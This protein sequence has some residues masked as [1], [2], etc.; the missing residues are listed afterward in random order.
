[1]L[2]LCCTACL[3]L[4]VSLRACRLVHC[5]GCTLFV[6]SP[7]IHHLRRRRRRQHF[8]L[9]VVVLVVVVIVIAVCQPRALSLSSLR[10]PPS[11]W[12]L[13]SIV[14]DVV[15]LYVQSCYGRCCHRGVPATRVVVVVVVVVDKVILATKCP[16][17]F[18]L[19]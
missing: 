15:S 10:A 14:T 7:F 6:S 9:L 3:H 11:S 17:G 5:V 8:V 13:S 18:G 2:C 1:M 12:E 19:L 4:C 16:V